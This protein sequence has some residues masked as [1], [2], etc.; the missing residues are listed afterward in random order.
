MVLVLADSSVLIPYLSRRAYIQRVEHELSRERLV[1]CSVVATEIMVG[2][3]DQI[4]RRRYD[5]FVIAQL[6]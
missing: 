1:L 2:A 3:R 4:E 6:G 5:R